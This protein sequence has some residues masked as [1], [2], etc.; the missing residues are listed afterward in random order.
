MNASR[1][2]QTNDDT[3]ASSS[4]VPLRLPTSSSGDVKPNVQ[5]IDPA[6]R[7]AFQALPQ[8]IYSAVGVA[9]NT[10]PKTKKQMAAQLDGAGVGDSSSDEDDDDNEIPGVDENDDDLN[11]DDEPSDTECKEDPDPLNSD[12]DLTEP[13][14][15]N[16]DHDLFDTDHVIVCQYNKVNFI[17]FLSIFT[18]FKQEAF[19]KITRIKNKWKFQL[20]D[21]IMNINGKDYLFSKATGDAEW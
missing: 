18:F 11:N 2:I 14:S 13:G 5:M 7:A 9:S 4:D 6:T 8:A 16:S 17:V 15:P 1:A 19:L 20:Q 21:G 12:D 10:D 3:G